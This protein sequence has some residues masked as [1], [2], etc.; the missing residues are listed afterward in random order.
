VDAHP[1]PVHGNVLRIQKLLLDL[2]QTAPIEAVDVER[3]LL[4]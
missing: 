1:D 3:F 2:E 4:R